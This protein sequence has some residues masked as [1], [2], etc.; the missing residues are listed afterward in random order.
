MIMSKRVKWVFSGHKISREVVK[1]N[2]IK[3]LI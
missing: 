3:A 2:V 1:R